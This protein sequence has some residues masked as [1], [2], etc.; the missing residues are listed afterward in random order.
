MKIFSRSVEYYYHCIWFILSLEYSRSRSYSNI[1]YNN[2]MTCY[3]KHMK[4][5]KFVSNK[6]I[7]ISL[8]YIIPHFLNVKKKMHHWIKK[9]IIVLQISVLIPFASLTPRYLHLPSSIHIQLATIYSTL[10]PPRRVIHWHFAT[11]KS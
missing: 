7:N 11:L 2:I 3:M 4:Q 5:R 6:M 8:V 9:E 1:L 10:P